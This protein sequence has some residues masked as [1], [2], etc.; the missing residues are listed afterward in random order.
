[1]YNALKM[2]KIVQEKYANKQFILYSII[3]WDLH[4]LKLGLFSGLP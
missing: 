1:M 4:F 3:L 2:A